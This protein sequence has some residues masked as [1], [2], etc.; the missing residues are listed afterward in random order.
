[1]GSIRL[2]MPVEIFGLIFD[3]LQGDSRCSALAILARVCRVFK[4]EK[5]RGM[6][7]VFMLKYQRRISP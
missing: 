3:A 5:L 6:G 4:G 7:V 1:M 2:P